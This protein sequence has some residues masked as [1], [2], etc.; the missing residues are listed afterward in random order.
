VGGFLIPYFS[1]IQKYSEVTL[2][3][4]RFMSGDAGLDDAD[5]KNLVFLFLTLIAAVLLSRW[6][7]FRAYREIAKLQD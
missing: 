6:L 4:T 3:L 5:V 1:L 2:V 7:R